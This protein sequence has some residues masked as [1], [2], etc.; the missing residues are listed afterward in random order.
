MI[1]IIQRLGINGSSTYSATGTRLG[2]SRVSRS[3][4]SR[5]QSERF[6]T[7]T[8]PASE[9]W[10]SG[11]DAISYDG[12]AYSDS[13]SQSSRPTTRTGWDNFRDGDNVRQNSKTGSQRDRGWVKQG[14]VPQNPRDKAINQL[15]REDDRE[16]EAEDNPT[17]ASD[18][19]DDDEDDDPY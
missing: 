19:E 16:R 4:V 3:D 5:A 2:G 11:N 6:E 18:D 8:N 1:L 12:S 7:D 9:N 14:A 15:H 10:V 17:M 13:L